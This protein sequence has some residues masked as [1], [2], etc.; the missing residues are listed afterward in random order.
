MK[1]LIVGAG[2]YVTGRDGSGTGTILSAI[3][4]YS[5]TQTVHEVTVVSPSEGNAAVVEQESKRI[6]ETLGTSCNVTFKQV[7][8]TDDLDDLRSFNEFDAAIVSVPDHLHFQYAA[9]T[10]EAGI[11]TLVVKP[12][13][14]T[15][16]EALQLKSIQDKSGAY[17]AVEF[18]KRWDETNLITKKYIE[19]GKL[20]QL[21]YY[22]VG[23]SQR[24]SIPLET[25]KSW[26]DQ[27][28][29]FQYLGVHYVD[30]YYFLTGYQPLRCMALGTDGVLKKEGVNTWDSIHVMVEWQNPKDDSKSVANFNTNWIDPR[31]TSAMS[32]QRYKIIGTKGRLEIDQKHRGV[33]FVSEGGTEHLNP[34]FS[35][36]LENVDGETDFTGYGPKS[37]IQFLEDVATGT[38]DLDMKRPSLLESLVSTAVIDAVNQSL[39]QN[40]AWVDIDPLEIIE[41][42]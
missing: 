20:G 31:K 16:K 24:I 33:E 22:D 7:S 40:G 36:Y 21:L 2:M 3:A 42:K 18:H 25:F 12:L 1:I 32:D 39:E 38:S 6:N 23:Y 9:Y 29:I 35:E 19:E 34:Y 37:I 14:P 26:S 4:Q 27:T 8:N 30:L 28:N 11:P 10:L 41:W 15:L 17:C 13:T 5:K